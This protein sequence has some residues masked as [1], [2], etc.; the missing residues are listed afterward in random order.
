MS[1][2]GSY[3]SGGMYGGGYGG[4]G[5]SRYGFQGNSNSNFLDNTMNILDSFSFAVNSLCDIARNLEMNAEGLSRFGVSFMGLGKRIR[6]F[7]EGTVYFFIGIVKKIWEMFLKKFGII[8]HLKYEDQ[9][10]VQ[11]YFF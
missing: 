2:Y 10:K 4:Y 3:G 6:N 11:M 1:S 9:S 8:M 5:R 7:S